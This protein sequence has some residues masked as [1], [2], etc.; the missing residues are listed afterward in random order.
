MMFCG[1]PNL[2]LDRFQQPPLDQENAIGTA[3]R[4][5]ATPRQI[6]IGGFPSTSR[7]W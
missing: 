7:R 5:G 6:Q 3:A 4:Q 1:K 2:Y